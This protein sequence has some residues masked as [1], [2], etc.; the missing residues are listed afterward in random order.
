MVETLLAMYL[1]ANTIASNIKKIKAFAK[2]KLLI[3]VDPAVEEEIIISQENVAA[4][5]EWIAQ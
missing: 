3:D 2:S 1:G 4:F 5:K